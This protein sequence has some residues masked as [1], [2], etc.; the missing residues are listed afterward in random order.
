MS[1]KSPA[2]FG[3]PPI[4]PFTGLCMTEQGPAG[5][6]AAQGA[7]LAE[8]ARDAYIY[9]L[10]LNIMY[11][12]RY[13]ALFNPENPIS[14][15]NRINTLRRNRE[16]AGPHSRAVTAPNNDTIYCAAWLDLE[17]EP[18]VIHV[19]DTAGRYYSV[20][21]LDMYTNNFAILGRRATG[22]QEGDYVIAGPGWKGEPP[23]GLRVFESPTKHAWTIVRILVD[24]PEDLPK[25]HKIQDQIRLTPLSTFTGGQPASAGTEPA[26]AP[27]QVDMDDPVSY[28]T[29]AN[30]VL[31]DNPPPA[32]EAALL[33]QFQKIGVG[34]GQTFDLSRFSNAEREQILKGFEQGKDALREAGRARGLGAS[35]A[36]WF[37]PPTDLGIY[38]SNYLLRAM[39]ATG[40]LG[41]FPNEEAMYFGTTA[42][43]EGN[44][45]DGRNRYVL[46]FGPGE[47]P[48]ADAFWSLTMYKTEADMRSFLVENPIQR[49]SIGDRTK[50][51]KY[52][53]DGSL[54][55]YL[56]HESPGPDKESNWLPAPDTIFRL[57]LRM[58]QPRQEVL[59]RKYMAPPV[60]RAE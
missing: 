7:D 43:A 6:G 34:P 33:E 17:P 40:G 50:G 41:A 15:H 14:I 9:V 26:D 45:L 22:T 2:L 25:V 36:G 51:L 37:V 29:V 5:S 49:Y 53:P 59:D 39:V 32:G 54:S 12:T 46:H 52:G 3:V 31:T 27:V 57:S 48:P 60:R 16:L 55:L 20:Q 30:R 11:R 42:D 35:G 19:P 28:F 58:Y 1:K 4:L 18:L 56:Q 47:L 23:K 24:G 21:F 10:P 38:G 8:I 44:P 13:N